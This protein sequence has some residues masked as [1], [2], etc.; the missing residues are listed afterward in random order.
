MLS[1][2]DLVEKVT[3]DIKDKSVY[4]LI[5]NLLDIINSLVL[6]ATKETERNEQNMYW[7]YGDLVF[8]LYLDAISQKLYEKTSEDEMHPLIEIEKYSNSNNDGCFDKLFKI[9]SLLIWW[10]INKEKQKNW[11]IIIKIDAHNSPLGASMYS[12]VSKLGKFCIADESISKAYSLFFCYNA[13]CENLIDN[14]SLTP[15]TIYTVHRDL[16]DKKTIR[17][18]TY[19]KEGDKFFRYY[20]GNIT[21]ETREEVITNNIGGE[22]YYLDFL[23]SVLDN[24]IT[25]KDSSF[26]EFYLSS[27]LNDNTWD[28]PK[29]FSF[30]N[31]GLSGFESWGTLMVEDCNDNASSVNDFF[32]RNIDNGQREDSQVLGFIKS[33]ISALKKVDNEYNDAYNQDRIKKESI[34][35]SIAAIMSRNMSHNLGSH[36]ISNTKNYFNAMINYDSEHAAVYRGVTYALQYIQERMDFIAAVTSDD[37]NPFGAVNAKAQIL[38]ELTPDDMGARH[39]KKSFNFLMD[40]LVLSEKIS[41]NS[42]LSLDLKKTLIVSPGKYRLKLRMG[43]KN[44]D[45]EVVFWEP[46]KSTPNENS[47]RDSLETISFAI[48]GGILGRHALFSIIENVIRNA[49]KHGQ[50]MIKRDFVISMLYQQDRFIIFDNK[51]DEKIKNTADNLRTR[52]DGIRMINNDGSLNQESK[53]LKEILIC[54]IWLQNHYFAKV[55]QDKHKQGCPIIGRY[56]EYVRIIAVDDN[57]QELENIDEQTH[58]H[59]GYSISLNRFKKSIHLN[60]IPFIKIENGRIFLESLKS[61]N[62]DI[63]CANQ[64]YVVYSQSNNEKTLKEIFPRFK[65]ISVEDYEKQNEDEL[66]KMIV[67]DNLHVDCDKMRMVISSDKHESFEDNSSIPIDFYDNYNEMSKNDFLFKTH[68]GKSKWD[69]FET[70]YL[71]PGFENKYIDSISGGDFTHTL[72]QPSFVGDP[73]NLYK[74]YESVKTRFVIIDERIFEQHCSKRK[75]LR[76]D[77]IDDIQKGESIDDIVNKISLNLLNLKTIENQDREKIRDFVSR[78]WPDNLIDFL[79]KDIE[80][81][82]LERKDIHLF[83]FNNTENNYKLQ[84]LSYQEYGFFGIKD[85]GKEAHFIPEKNSSYFLDNVGEHPLTFLSIHLGLI[86]KVKDYLGVELDSTFDESSIVEEL[87]KYF[88]ASFVS[89]HSGRGGFDIR[90]ELKKYTFQSYSAV[91]SP[92]YNS[93]FLLAQQ[94][95]NLNYYGTK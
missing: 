41:K 49:A 51:D 8:L 87:K 37:V 11:N 70:L 73:Y 46:S 64:N 90:G 6:D 20:D 83:C 19:Q 28:T 88:G 43:F 95:Y 59:L 45:G 5:E 66:L 35:S 74:I 39:D 79:K 89:I 9:T 93:K 1:K 22:K 60:T 16:S 48:P 4:K 26:A 91:E 18:I 47:K 69:M 78:N 7:Q 15:D 17:S 31:L 55:F 38:D 32:Y 33:I 76:G 71:T 80:Q 92:L 62:A 10:L 2:K 13:F 82:F 52:L 86:D 57:G 36:F 58:G 3:N 94:F 61:L 34:R 14:K 63:I 44:D 25:K 53:G 24:E 84:D 65:E 40:N 29:S 75:K 30:F 54:A 21:P 12:L 77:L 27:N 50:E 42:Y 23:R 81:H 56:D 67:N 68:A 85:N 72:V